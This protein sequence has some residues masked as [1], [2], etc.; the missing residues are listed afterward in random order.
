MAPD[1]ST[2]SNAA[3][4]TYL[5]LDNEIYQRYNRFRPEGAKPLF[6]YVPFNNIF[7]S[8]SGRVLS[9]PY[10]QDVELGKYPEKSVHEIWFSESGRQ[11]RSHLEH[12][13]LSMGCK[14]CK[15]YFDKEKFT[16]LKPLVFDKYSDY[17]QNQYPKVLEFSL[18]NLCNLE[19]KMCDGT[20]SSS[21]RKNRDKLP[22][23]PSPYDDSFVEQLDEFIPHIK[24][25]KFYGGEPFL[26]PVYFKIWD[27]I[28]ALN[29]TTQIFVITNGTCW[30]ARIEEYLNKGNFDLAVSIDGATKETYE[31]IRKNANYEEV[32]YN[33]QKFNDYCLR[34]NKVLNISFTCQRNNWKELPLM[35]NLC[36]KLNA[37]IYVSYIH[38]PQDLAHWNLPSHLI[39]MIHTELAAYTFPEKTTYQKHNAQCYKD[40]LNYLEQ[41]A[42]KNLKQEKDYELAK[43]VATAQSIV[44][45]IF[46]NSREVAL[47]GSADEI[48]EMLL[49]RIDKFYSAQQQTQHEHALSEAEIMKAKT[50]EVYAEVSD[51]LSEDV[52]YFM[53]L[54]TDINDVLTDLKTQTTQQ[55]ADR[56]RNVFTNNK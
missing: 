8:F 10:N 4:V 42:E 2:N 33:L 53:G 25:A 11:L 21:I 40:Y 47:L 14:H 31:H 16:G 50:K 28:I 18:S 49:K 36:N 6:C 34:N 45:H 26:I 15:H 38:Y 37:Q 17:Q 44:H 7:F 12:N 46:P 51:I 19:C 43:Q 24:E 13:D 27:K 20:V 1:N 3:E 9:C 48:R 55:L 22:P 23:I 5:P 54:K 41:C 52:F 56:L 32:F 35:V 30:N 39:K 29:P